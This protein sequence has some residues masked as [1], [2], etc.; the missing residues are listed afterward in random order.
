MFRTLLALA[1]RRLWAATPYFVPDDKTVEQLC[2]LA[3]DG[4]DVRI[5]LPG[6]HIDQAAV[7]LASERTMGTLLE[8]GVRIHE[9]DP[10]M[11]HAKVLIVDDDL[12]CVGSANMNQRSLRKDDEVSAVLSSPR[13]VEVLGDHFM[14]DLGRST[15]RSLRGWREAWWRRALGALLAPFRREL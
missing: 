2:R 12:A 3:M 8:A 7:R 10:T 11:M 13:L 4:A 14:A 1:E 15:E 6:E 9:Y 5:L